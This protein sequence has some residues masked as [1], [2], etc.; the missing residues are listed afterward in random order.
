MTTITSQHKLHGLK[1][2]THH[3]NR[4]PTTVFYL[5]LRLVLVAVGGLILIAALFVS[6]TGNVAFIAPLVVVWVTL[7]ATAIIEWNTR[8]NL[9]VYLYEEGFVLYRGKQMTPVLWNDITSINQQAIRSTLYGVEVGTY[10]TY[11]VRTTHHKTIRLTKA[12]LDIDLLGIS[13]Q[14]ATF[15]ALYNQANETYQAGQPVVFGPVSV[16]KEGITTGNRKIVWQ[17]IRAIASKSSSPCGIR[18]VCLPGW[19]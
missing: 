10:Y 11:T 9:H 2:L 19:R 17:D 16:D 18:G 7:A 4:N 6:G 3:Y 12:I 1:S 15:E 13:I 8:H 14:H 5:V